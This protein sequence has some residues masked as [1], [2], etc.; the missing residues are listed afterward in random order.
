MVL[1]WRA[2]VDGV[3]PVE[4]V[5]HRVGLVELERIPRLRLDVDADHLK[6]GTVVADRGATGPAEQIEETRPAHAGT[7]PGV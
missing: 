1:A 7:S 3:E 2:G 4:R 5:R 6:P